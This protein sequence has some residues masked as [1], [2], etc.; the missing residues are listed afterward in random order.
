MMCP[1][2]K[3][4]AN[5]VARPEW[6]PETITG[7]RVDARHDRGLGDVETNLALLVSIKLS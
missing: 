4:W 3:S 5:V 1:M 7:Q 2:V 6:T